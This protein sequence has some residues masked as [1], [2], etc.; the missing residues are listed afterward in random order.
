M[1]PAVGR[2]TFNSA[3][4]VHGDT[5]AAG[6]RAEEQKRRWKLEDERRLA[7]MERKRETIRC[8]RAAT[9]APVLSELLQSDLLHYSL[10]AGLL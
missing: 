8:R 1:V 3:T 7:E 5:A 4:H 2:G 6:T 10:T 9:G